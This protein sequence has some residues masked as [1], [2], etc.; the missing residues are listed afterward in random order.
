MKYLAS[1]CLLTLAGKS[2]VNASDLVNVLNA[3]G[4]E[5]TEQNAQVVCT[6]L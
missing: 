5:S 3:I 6:Q 2:D 1:Y 4:A